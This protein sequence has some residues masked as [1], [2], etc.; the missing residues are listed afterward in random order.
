VHHW[1]L[2]FAQ[3]IFGDAVN[4]EKVESTGNIH[5]EQPE[6]QLAQRTIENTLGTENN[7]KIQ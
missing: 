5:A 1:K 7:R 6:M 2:Q 3:R 4:T